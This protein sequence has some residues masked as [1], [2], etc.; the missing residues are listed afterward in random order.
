M[1]NKK[2]RAQLVDWRSRELLRPGEVAELIGESRS[3]VYSRIARGQLP[4]VRLGKS[5]RVP[6]IKLEEKL[7]ELIGERIEA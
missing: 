7:A 1:Q 4:A 6:R 2:K 3:G 5:V